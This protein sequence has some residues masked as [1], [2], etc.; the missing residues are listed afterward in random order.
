MVSLL[1]PPSSKAA[2]VDGITLASPDASEPADVLLVDAGSLAAALERDADQIIVAG[3]APAHRLRRHGYEVM[4]VLTLPSEA[5]PMLMLPLAHHN[6]YKYAF[7]NLVF[8]RTLLKRI[9]KRF[10]GRALGLIAPPNLPMLTLAQKTRQAPFLLAAATELGVPADNRWFLRIGQGSALTRCSFF[11]FAPESPQPGWIVKFARF[12]GC[13]DRFDADERGLALASE[14]GTIVARHAPQLLGRFEVGGLA[15]SVETAAPGK[16]LVD[17]LLASG[18]RRRKLALIE[19]IAAWIVEVGVATLAPSER[20]GDEQLRIAKDVLPLAG[21]ERGAELLERV[22]KVGAVLQ[23]NDLGCW[24]IVVDHGHFSALDWEAARRHGYPLWDL[25]FFLSDALATL[26]RTTREERARYFVRLFRGELPSS[27]VLFSW[28]R[29]SVQALG[30]AAETV[31]SLASLCW[32]H[33]ASSERKTHR[34]LTKRGLSTDVPS[35][36][37][38]TLPMLWLEEPG[39]GPDW[40]RWNA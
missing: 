4:R 19:D 14:A 6:A 16:P 18:M 28:T 7:D 23:H 24:N 22:Q 5:N 3:R 33:H 32:L 39:L 25:W 11:V 37:M 30:L 9:R 35:Q 21:L 27:A 8:P 17:V 36:L 10:V 31:G 15:A 29:R 13:E 26:D 1:G 38:L 20:T 2:T 12:R 34:S 40:S